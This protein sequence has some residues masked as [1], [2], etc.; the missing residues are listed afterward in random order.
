MANL[1]V[2][3]QNKSMVQSQTI[4]DFQFIY[5]YIYNGPKRFKLSQV[6]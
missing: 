2:T 4:T 5:I 1:F 6:I 3:F